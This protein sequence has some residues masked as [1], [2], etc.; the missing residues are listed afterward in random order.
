MKANWDEAGQVTSDE[1]RVTSGRHVAS[2]ECRVTSVGA[3]EW[4]PPV[5][6]WDFRSI[7]E[8]ESRMA[9]CWEYAR[10]CGAISENLIGW[11][12]GAGGYTTLGEF[13]CTHGHRFPA[14][15]IMAGDEMASFAE[16]IEAE[17]SPITVYSLTLR[18]DFVMQEVA[19]AIEDGRDVL[20]LLNKLLLAD[21]YVMT[22]GFETAGSDA[23]VKALS[24]WAR[25]EAKKFPRVRR[26]KG[27]AP[28]FEWLKW[29]AALRLEAARKEAG[30]SFAEVQAML[31]KHQ[32][33]HP[34]VDAS[35]TLPVYASH[36]AWSKAIGEA[37][38]W[39]AML[40]TDPVAFERRVMG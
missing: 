16:G 5:T 22:M 7:R 21:G 31:V 10:S 28:P 4:L 19:E 6:E 24:G 39:L 26:G 33:E 8:R 13:I 20:A 38:K 11:L 1:C 34:I 29:L 3:E 12:D 37:R 18:K 14:P 35:P 36:G 9:C 30:V 40:E 27:S 2:D 23:V 17:A 15:W 32:L 25:Q